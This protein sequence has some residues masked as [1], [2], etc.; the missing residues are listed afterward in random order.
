MAGGATRPDYSDKYSDG[1]YEYRYDLTLK[2]P[3]VFFFV[4][5]VILP[6]DWTGRLPKNRLL[7][8]QEW[9][10]LGVQQ[11]RGWAHYAYHRPEPNILLFRRPLGTDPQTGD[12]NPEL[13]RQAKDDYQREVAV[14]QRK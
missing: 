2:L 11:S 4:R 9:R 8:E 5:H 14:H 10:N 3:E 1:I 13:E 12:V 7:D 6:K